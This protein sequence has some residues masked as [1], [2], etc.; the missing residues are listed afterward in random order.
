ME[1]LK[2]HLFRFLFLSLFVLQA[3]CSSAQK[4][5]FYE[6]KIYHL[7]SDSQMTIVDHYLE[8]AYL[9]ALH[10]MGIGKIGVFK[11]LANDTATDKKIYLLI[12]FHDLNEVAV[13][14]GKLQKDEKY[15]NADKAYTQAVYNKPPFS[16]IESILLQAF[17]S[18]PVLKKPVLSGP[19]TDRIYELRSYEGPTEAIHAN[20]IDMF[21]KGGEFDIFKR[22][23][24]NIVFCAEVISGTHMP[25]LM[26]MPT[27]EN[28]ADH[29]I[30]WKNFGSDPKWKSLSSLPGYQN[31]VSHID[32]VFMH[33]ASYSDL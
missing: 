19:M 31:N 17:D 8:V 18:F 21:N 24:F 10:R 9:P 3:F 25:N 13:L 12:P 26:Y 32:V 27:F 2:N 33:P 23:N 6:I 30:H 22:L 28:M 5:N 7:A 1:I 11:P 29:D 14:P 20:K 16:R 15:L 4:K